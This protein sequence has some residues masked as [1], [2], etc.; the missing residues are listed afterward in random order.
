MSHSR[1]SG[2]HGDACTSRYIG[3]V[4]SLLFLLVIP[5]LYAADP[6]V[7]SVRCPQSTS[8]AIPGVTLGNLLV[9]A[10]ISTVG[11]TISDSQ[12]NAYTVLRSVDT[13]NS[14]SG[15]AVATLTAGGVVTVKSTTRAD[16]TLEE[17]AGVS[18]T[19]DVADSFAA[20][21]SNSVC[22]PAAPLSVT[23]KA[24][25]LL[26][27]IWAMDAGQAAS[28]AATSGTMACA[29]SCG[30][31]TG[32][33]RYEL[34]P[35]GVHTQ[36][37]T[38][39]PGYNG[40]TT[41]CG[42]YAL[43]M[44]AVRPTVAQ[45]PPGPCATVGA[46][47]QWV[48]MGDSITDNWFRGAA[49]V[50]AGA[51][52]SGIPGNTTQNMIDRF[53]SAVLNYSPYGMVLMG[54]INDIDGLAGP[55]T[56]VAIAGR[57]TAMADMALAAGIKVV[58]CSII[59]LGSLRGPDPGQLLAI[60]QVNALVRAYVAAHPS[61]VYCD[62]FSAMVGEN[63]LMLPG[64]SEDGLHPN[65]AGYAVMYPLTETAI[66]SVSVLP[67][68]AG[69]RIGAILNGAS[70]AV[71]APIAPGSFASV[72]GSGFGSRDQ[73]SGFPATSFNGV[74]VTFNGI[75]APLFHLI[76]SQGQ[77]NLLV[78]TSLPETGNTT[79]VVTAPD[80]TSPTF[81]LPMSPAAPGVFT[82]PSAANP[83]R[84]TAIA[85]FAGTAWR[86]MPDALARELGI[87]GNCLDS[88]DPAIICGE[89]AR[90]GD[91]IQLYVTGLGKATP[92]GIAEGVPLATGAV[93]PA[94]GNPL[95]ITVLQPQ[96]TFGGIPAQVLFS[97]VAPGFAGLYQINVR[98]PE[99]APS[100][101]DVPFQITMPNGQVDA[102]TSI[103]IR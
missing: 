70:F 2:G 46:A 71:G 28:C 4:R 48:F 21:G 45:G 13:Y 101:D 17:F 94:D 23:T 31:L 77:I 99:S 88:V 91:A 12:N 55:T 86:V 87:P 32:Q 15:L 96:V 56:P 42:L 102:S 44:V 11:G 18:L 80:A 73:L 82:I 74:S 81:T 60:T 78:P 29:G 69:P 10:S 39:L 51:I 16:L 92:N 34:A 8:C 36:Q 47:N 68:G 79:V 37:F 30:G 40:G 61:T 103:A 19:L 97:G 35:A 58:M 43:K 5:L 24:D 38:L 57:L 49:Q 1:L 76:G 59:P 95:Y 27:S 64:L 75:Q 63:G 85:L 6:L 14:H 93:A 50:H 65:A 20:G 89:P 52:N 100:G 67:I 62:Y 22:P 25:A 7:N 3:A 84:H 66:N 54:G 41:N 98:I 26:L 83:K 9:V 72:F 90:P 33:L 53:N